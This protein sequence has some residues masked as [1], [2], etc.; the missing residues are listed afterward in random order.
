MKIGTTVGAYEVTARIGVGGMGE[1]YQALDSRLRREVAIKVLPESVSTDAD[2][3]SRLMDEARVL[4]ALNHPNVAAIYD[5]VEHEGSTCLVMEFVPGETLG[6]RIARSPLPLDEALPLLR[7]LTDGLS[8]AHDKGIVHRDLKPDNIKLTPDGQVKILDFGLAK[9]LVEELMSDVGQES[10]TRTRVRTAAGVVLGTAHYMSPEQARGKPL[11]RRSDIWAFGCVAFEALAGV[12]AFPGESFSDVA[13]AILRREPD[14]SLLPTDLPRNAQVVLHRCLEKDVN[15][16]IRD[17]GDVRF[18]LDD[19]STSS[20][21]LWTDSRPQSVA[22]DKRRPWIG[23]VLSGLVLGI[24]LASAIRW[25]L[26]EPG[27]AEPG[28]TTRTTIQLLP[29]MAFRTDNTNLAISADGTTLVFAATG[30]EPGLYQRPMDQLKA[31]RIP[32]I[33]TDETLSERGL[34]LSPDGKWLGYYDSRQLK[35]VALAGGEPIAIAD[36]GYVLGIGA[37]WSDD[38][39]IF[40]ASHEGLRRVSADGGEAT[41]IT[42]IDRANSELSHEDPHVLPGGKALLYSAWIGGHSDTNRIAVVSLETGVQR[43]LIEGGSHARYIPTGHVVY[44]RDGVLLAAPF[45]VDTLELTGSPSVVVK[46]L[47]SDP[48][49]GAKHFAISR[50]G[51]LVYV[52]GGGELEQNQLYRARRPGHEELITD[53][54]GPYDFP[55]LSVGGDRLLIWMFEKNRDLWMY[56]LGRNLWSRFTTFEGWDGFPVWS[57][58]GAVVAFNSSRGGGQGDGWFSLYSRPADGSQPAELVYSSEDSVQPTSW[59]SDG[60]YLIF[61]KVTATGGGDLWTL[62]MNGSRMPSPLIATRFDEQQ[63]ALSPDGKWI[64][65][66]SDESGQFEIYVAPFPEPTKRW[67]ISRDGGSQP[68]WSRDGRQLHY[69]VRGDVAVVP[70]R[71]GPDF[72][73]GEPK[74][75]VKGPN[76]QGFDAS[77]DGVI[78]IRRSQPVTKTE[79][80]VVHNWFAELERLASPK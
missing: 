71:P 42:K 14:W 12:K 80:T 4:A 62:D 16:R 30:D 59:S 49:R 55:K 53:R 50:S 48:G 5:L 45:D 54:M 18:D 40:F 11:D 68:I 29:G 65:Y 46:D 25:S 3:M 28:P 64:A 51:L 36:S 69:F 61:S 72:F 7:Q 56:D 32:V 31:V 17:I 34:F 20:R 37:S 47:F 63:G 67:Q 39:T 73:V 23:A 33:S 24:V 76:I 8:A 66:Q 15:K 57:P 35:K 38:G 75:F 19:D 22:V 43:V 41:L 58:D 74:V 77:D 2:R 60:R 52:P 21:Y 1:V 70:L 26:A 9:P 78:F 27:A 10:R 44:A 6:D 13:V 79:L